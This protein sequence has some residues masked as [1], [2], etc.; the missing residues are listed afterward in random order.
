ML[1]DRRKL[2]INEL[3]QGYSLVAIEADSFVV[4]KPNGEAVLIAQD[5]RSVGVTTRPDTQHVRCE[6]RLG[7][8]SSVSSYRDP[9]D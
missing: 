7:I 3:P 1:P 4:R 9:M 5:G 6:E 2:R 8:E